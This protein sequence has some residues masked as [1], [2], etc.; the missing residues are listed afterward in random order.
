MPG[1]RG[2]GPMRA[3]CGSGPERVTTQLARAVVRGTDATRPM[4]PTSVW[5]ISTARVSVVRT[6]AMAR[7]DWLNSNSVGSAAAV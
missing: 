2:G 6:P 1:G 4:D 7:P 5:T 3:G